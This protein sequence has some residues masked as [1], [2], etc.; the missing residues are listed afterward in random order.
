[1]NATDLF[2]LPFQVGSSI[3]RRRVFHP[4]GVLAH[5]H[6][7]RRSPTGV[8]LPIESADVLGRI[9]KAVGLPGGL[10]DLMGLAWRMPPHDS[11]PG[12]WDVLAVSAGSGLLT[13]F[14]LRPTRSWSGTTLTTLMPLRQDDGWWWV[15]AQMKTV[16]AGGLTLDAVRS[17]IDGGGV[18]FDVQQAHGTGP[19]EPLAVLTLTASIPTDEQHDVS[20]DPA[21]NTAPGVELGPQW[22]TELRERAYRLSRRGRQAPD[23]LLPR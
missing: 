21:R 15:K 20:F 10:P 14:A 18:E 9:S 22:L 16:V 13:R 23:G 11:G 19:F 5:G 1:M 3:R 2:G 8:G 17:A 12:P 4:V 6:I 7:E